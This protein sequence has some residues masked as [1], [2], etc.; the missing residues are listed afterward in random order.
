MFTAFIA[1]S[2]ELVSLTIGAM[3][4]LAACRDCHRGNCASARTRMDDY[5][6]K[7]IE[8]N[9]SASKEYYKRD[10]HN[11]SGFLKAISFFTMALSLVALVSTCI[12]LGC[13]LADARRLERNSNAPIEQ[14]NYDL[15]KLRKYGD[16]QG[17]LRRVI[18]NR[19]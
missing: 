4:L 5:R 7:G 10:H 13:F 19:E 18:P 1:I 12:A 2:L 6:E 11:C 14:Y 16:N 9:T 17:V 8:T 15:N 3:L